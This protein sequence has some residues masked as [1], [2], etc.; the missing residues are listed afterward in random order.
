MGCSALHGHTRHKGNA[1]TENP[2]TNM[3]QELPIMLHPYAFDGF[4]HARSHPH[5]APVLATIL[6]HE[7]SSPPA[8]GL[9]SCTGRIGVLQ[10]QD[11]DTDDNK[12]SGQ[13]G[14]SC[15][16]R[17]VLRLSVSIHAVAV[18]VSLSAWAF[19]HYIRSGISMPKS[20]MPRRMT[21]ATALARE[22]RNIFSDSSASPRIVKS[23]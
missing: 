18:N 2:L 10:Q 15:P 7:D 12:N 17:K 14:E 23:W 21:L 16:L 4:T 13:L 22:R 11:C 19:S 3:L 1:P 8:E 6:P 20:P 9:Q 5:H